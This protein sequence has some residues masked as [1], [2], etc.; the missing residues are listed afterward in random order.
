MDRFSTAAGS[1]VVSSGFTAAGS[2][3]FALGNGQVI[4]DGQP[5]QPVQVHDGGLLAATFSRD[6]RVMLSAGD[7]GRICATDGAGNSEKLLHMPG[8][9]F[10]QLVAGPQ[11]SIGFAEGR[12]A[13]VRL[14]DG[15]VKQ[16]D[17][18]RAVGGIAF[19]PK[20]FR[21]AAAHYNGATIH[22][23]T[24]AGRPTRFEWKGAHLGA[25]FSPDGAF[26]ITHMQEN[27]LHG[28]RLADGQD[29]R[30]S[31]YPGKVKSSSW[32][33][34]GH[35]LATSG[36]DAAVLW[37]FKGKGG[38]MGKQPIQKGL[39][40]GLS[41]VVCCHPTR[42][43]VAT[44][45]ADGLILLSAIDGDNDQ[46]IRPA[47]DDPITTLAWDAKG[48]RLAFGTRDGALGWSPTG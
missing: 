20:G 9:W 31:G 15:T 47:N 18:D 28:W 8:K 23:V 25:T 14:A 22:W 32:S 2:A 16:F 19:H 41:T 48:Q 37:P 35:Y 33:A 7:D 6:G 46:Q 13:Y 24:S 21:L 40:A 34:K 5:D 39:G 26:L 12:R 29:L 30:M 36:A 43:Q 45:F 1:Y 42:L 38:P 11:S 10:D 3:M 4:I 27:A 17:H 44:G